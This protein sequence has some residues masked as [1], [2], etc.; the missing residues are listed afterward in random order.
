MSQSDMKTVHFVPR[1]TET[2]G[3]SRLRVFAVARRLRTMGFDCEVYNPPSLYT[4]F[5][6]TLKRLREFFGNVKLLSCITR[7]GDVLFGQKIHSQLDFAFLVIMFSRFFGMKFIFDFDDA[8]FDRPL[9]RTKSLIRFARQVIVGGEYLKQYALQFNKRVT[10]IPTSYDPKIYD[11]SCY[12]KREQGTVVTIGWIG[13]GTHH[14]E[15]LA[16]LVEPFMELAKQFT[17]RFVCIG[18]L[19]DQAIIDMFSS[20]SNFDFVR[21]DAIEWVDERIAATEIYQFDIGVM[22]LLDTVR[23]QGSCGGKALQYMLLAVPTVAS[24]VGEIQHFIKDG[25]NGYIA[26]SSQEWTNKLKSLIEDQGHRNRV[27]AAGR[28]TILSACN[29][30]TNIAVIREI[31]DGMFEPNR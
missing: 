23:A 11:I 18:V 9:W 17:L 4:K 22:P 5:D 28:E 3:S 8:I 7:Q 15:N 25:K 14:R 24:P 21:V 12:A 26:N 30:D 19:G 1:N 20:I 16:L 27:G 2:I 29:I 31:L 13:Y 10:V 6:L